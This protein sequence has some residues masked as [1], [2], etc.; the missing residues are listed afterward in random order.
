MT[1]VQS[2]TL[3]DVYPYLSAAAKI[4]LIASV[5]I[6]AAEQ[7]FSAMSRILR[8]LRN[9]LKA[10]HLDELMKILIEGSEI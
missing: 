1:L 5:S 9:R 8:K 3:R 7:N 10:I 2:G 4:F 6:A